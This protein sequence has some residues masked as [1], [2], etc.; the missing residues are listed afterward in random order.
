MYR[1]VLEYLEENALKYPEKAAFD[2]DKKIVT[3]HELMVQ[4]KAIGSALSTVNCVGKPVVVYLPKG[5]DCITS[6]MGIVYSGGFY[7]PID[8]KMPAD[9]V[10]AIFGVLKPAAIISTAKYAGK[11]R[12][13]SEDCPVL[14]FEECIATEAD[15]LFLS[16]V[17]SAMVDTDPLYVLF[18]SG[19]TGIPKG[20][21]VSHRSMIDFAEWLVPKFAISYTDII[22]NQGNFYF[23]LSVLDIYGGLKSGATVCIIPAKKF[24][25]PVDLIRFLNEKK[26][27]IINWVPSMICNVANMKALDVELPASLEKVLFCGEVMPAKQLNIWKNHLP[28]V[29]YV[30]LYGPTEIVYACTYFVIDRAFQDDEALPI[31]SAC[32]N[33]KI[34]VLNEKDELVQ[35]E[36]AGELCVGGTCVALGYYNNSD[37]TNTAFVQNPLN[38]YYNEMIYRTGDIVKYNELGE[39]MYLS[40]KDFQIKHMGHRIELGEIET[41]LL[42]NAFVENCACIYDDEAK[43]ICAFY[44][45]ENVD[46]AEIVNHLK[47]KIPAYMIP[48]KVIYL[49]RF[50]YNINGKI[51]RLALKNMK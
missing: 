3:F 48:G 51:D 36:E 30:N 39:L 46:A 11:I 12:E 26:I 15:T 17:R 43:E 49:D 45:G 22:G 19:S 21:V 14:L 10:S 35:G 16:R 4:A 38:P 44:I 9:R 40:R 6:F 18:T 42:D 29:M 5:C 41:A 34:L 20:V 33:T 37:K 13:I 32:E 7:C 1:N 28:D 24:M 50:P 25:F 2:D 23:D 31:G 47:S 27:T 8:V